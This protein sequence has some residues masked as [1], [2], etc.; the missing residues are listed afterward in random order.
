MLYETLNIDLKEI[1]LK[2][3]NIIS[4]N[5]EEKIKKEF[6]EFLDDFNKFYEKKYYFEIFDDLLKSKDEYKTIFIKYA[7]YIL[8]LNNENVD[9]NK[10]NNVYNII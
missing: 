4:L 5:D 6:T 8:L 10:I 1:L 2:N 3:S 9:E 7:S